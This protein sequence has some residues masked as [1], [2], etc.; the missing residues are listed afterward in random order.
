MEILMSAEALDLLIADELGKKV[1]KMCELS[2]QIEELKMNV[3]QPVEGQLAV[4]KKEIER[5][6]IETSTKTYKGLLW[7]ATLVDKVKESFSASTYVELYHAKMGTTMDEA[8]YAKYNKPIISY[9]FDYDAYINDVIGED[10]ELREAATKKV[11]TTYVLVSR[12]DK[13]KKK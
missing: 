7:Q 6:M 12:K 2:Q 8:T 9:A 4:I 1:D 3:I 5:E 10:K 11:G 13:K